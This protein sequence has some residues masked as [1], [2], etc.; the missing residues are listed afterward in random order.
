MGWQLAHFHQLPCIGT[1][2]HSFP[3]I[4]YIH[5]A[6]IL[7]FGTSPLA[8]RVVVLILTWCESMLVF[9]LARRWFSER[10]AFYAAILSAAFYLWSGTWLSAQLDVFA[11]FFILCGTAMILRW[12]SLNDRLPNIK[13]Q[14]TLYALAGALFG[15]ASSLRPTYALFAFALALVLILIWKHAA[16]RHILPFALGFAVV[17]FLTIVPYFFISG[18]IREL[19]FAAI[20]FNFDIYARPEYASPFRMLIHHRVELACD[21]ILLL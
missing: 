12:G 14:R 21:G 1:W 2:A 3:G 9:Y 13:S 7:C 15:L 10:F 18:G 20:R 8:L 11:T 17:F 4:E 5:A 16:F 6:I 19:Y